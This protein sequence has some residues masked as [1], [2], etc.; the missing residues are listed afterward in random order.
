MAPGRADIGLRRHHNR[1]ALNSGAQCAI[2]TTRERGA[3]ALTKIIDKLAWIHV[4]DGRILSTRSRGKDTYYIPGGKREAG[5]SDWAALRR[6]ISEELSIELVESTLE[7]AGIFEA[8][9]HGKD[10]GVF[11]RM[12]CYRA[13][14]TGVIEAASEIDDVVWLD[15]SG[16]AKSSP[17]DQIIFDALH[18]EG[19]LAGTEQ[20]ESGAGA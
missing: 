14:Y 11:V 4:I 5:E 20:E 8:Q 16:R 17:V 12:T 6:E 19:V 15:Y 3:A 10:S 2:R 18:K 9:A 7:P 13:D 1:L